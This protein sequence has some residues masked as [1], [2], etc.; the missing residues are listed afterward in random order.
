MPYRQPLSYLVIKIFSDTSQYKRDLSD[1]TQRT[2]HF[3][4]NTH[5]L[6]GVQRF[7]P[8][9]IIN[10]RNIRALRAADRDIRS[11]RMRLERLKEGYRSVGRA[12]INMA[13]SMRD[14]FK[15]MGTARAYSAFFERGVMFAQKWGHAVVGAF[16]TVAVS[17]WA[18]SRAFRAVWDGM[19][20]ISEETVKLSDEMNRIKN[21]AVVADVSKTEFQQL[22]L[23]AKNFSF[24]AIQMAD[25][26]NEIQKRASRAETGMKVLNDA[27]RRMGIELEG[28]ETGLDVLREVIKASEK[29][30]INS[31]QFR[32]DLGKVAGEEL[33]RKMLPLIALGVDGFDQLLMATEK[34]KNSQAEINA[35]THFHINDLIKEGEHTKKR[36]TFMVEHIDQL[37][38]VRDYHRG[39]KEFGL[40]MLGIFLDWA[41]ALE[42]ILKFLGQATTVATPGGGVYGLTRRNPAVLPGGDDFA[43]PGPAGNAFS[44]AQVKTLQD[45]EEAL[46]S[47]GEALDKYLKSLGTTAV[48]NYTKW[49]ELIAKH[50]EE[51]NAGI[52]IFRLSATQVEILGRKFEVLYEEVKPTTVEL[53]D[54]QKALEKITRIVAGPPTE[55]MFTKWFNAIHKWNMELD[56]GIDILNLS[57]QEVQNWGEAIERVLSASTEGMTDLQKAIL[58]A[59]KQ[60]A[61]SNYSQ[62]VADI[63]LLRESP[64]G[65]FADFSQIPVEEIRE[66]ARIMREPMDPGTSPTL[67]VEKLA[68]A[69]EDVGRNAREA[70]HQMIVLGTKASEV[71][72]RLLKTI[73][74]SIIQGQIGRWASGMDAGIFKDI[75]TGLAGRQHGGYVGSG[76]AY[77]VGERGPEVFMPSQSG[78]I[79]SNKD[80]MGSGGTVNNFTFETPASDTLAPLVRQEIEDAIPYILQAVNANNQG[81]MN[82]TRRGM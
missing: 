20:R 80:S 74:L 6:L 19:V 53:T 2:T 46:T 43:V 13:T 41:D 16:A 50:N 55:A 21:L 59:D 67:E 64:G 15:G 82:I 47:F 28:T 38:K 35:L 34:V 63:K 22:D 14:S 78:R 73:A 45:G 5:R 72:D 81:N 69:W 71:M 1:I 11:F 66:I 56:A 10:I 65:A 17:A 61:D 70:L 32:A 48:N 58:D 9:D 68:S 42:K 12:A 33:G 62:L 3:I 40:E 30:G 8:L 49:I 79:M 75:L 76:Q 52:D 36:N 44:R 51:T 57:E 24:T 29:L 77:L 4:K 60:I 25:G 31:Q 26:L 7:K 23:I 18:L 27:F 54:F 37:E 39:W